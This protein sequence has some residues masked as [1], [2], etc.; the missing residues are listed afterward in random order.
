MAKDWIPRRN[1]AFLMQARVFSQK[2]FDDPSRYGIDPA[3]AARLVADFADFDAKYRA[4]LE[5]LTRTTLGVIARDAARKTLSDRMR[6]LGAQIRANRAV[7]FERRFELL[8]TVNGRA[9]PAPQHP[10]ESRPV[11]T[12][13]SVIDDRLTLSLKNSGSSGRGVPRHYSGAQIFLLPGLFYGAPRDV[14][15]WRLAGVTSK[16]RTTIE[17]PYLKPGSALSLSAR[18][19][20]T[21]GAGPSSTAAYTYVGEILKT[22]L[23]A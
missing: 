6:A 4:A 15:Q 9:E 5:P 12:I 8:M 16:A 11:L 10:P 1:G 7:N 14:T 3:D 19:Y 21:H 2:I 17:L 23:V 22:P 18:W 20:N 13:V